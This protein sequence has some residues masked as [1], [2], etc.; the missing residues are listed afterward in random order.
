MFDAFKLQIVVGHMGEALPFMLPRLD[1][2]SM[3][4][5]KLKDPV[6]FYL[7]QNVHYTFSG[8]NFTPTFLDLFLEVGV[9]RIYVLGG[10]SLRVDVPSALVPVISSQSAHLIRSDCAPERRAPLP[11][12]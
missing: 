2:I 7:R 12:T 4:L 5:T 3:S 9:D 6:S 10:P 1:S 11:D 8:F